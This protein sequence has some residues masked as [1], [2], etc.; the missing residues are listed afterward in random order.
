[1][2]RN[3][4]SFDTL[5]QLSKEDGAATLTEFVAAAVE[6]GAAY[7]PAP[8]TQWFVTGGGRHNP[9][10]MKALR[11][12]FLQVFPVESLGWTGDA[13]E[14]QAFAFLAVRSLKKLAISLPTTTGAIRAV[15]GGALHRA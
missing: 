8:A 1:M 9:A 11:R 5:N 7:F 13:L 15:T 4:F 6:K 3:H 10:V 2:D 14:A 12:K